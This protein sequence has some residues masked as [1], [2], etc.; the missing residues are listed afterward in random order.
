MDKAKWRQIMYSD[1]MNIEVDNLKNR[2]QMRRMPTEKNN[3]DCIIRLTKQGS[4]SIGIWRC[5]SYY[6]LEIFSIFDGR[7]NSDR[8]V[9]RNSKLK[10]YLNS[11]FLTQNSGT[12]IPQTPRVPKMANPLKRHCE[13]WYKKQKPNTK[14]AKV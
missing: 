11:T 10:C 8:Y 9:S 13:F 12:K 14:N 2:I 4:C 1:E 7:L 3:E 6:R 5:M